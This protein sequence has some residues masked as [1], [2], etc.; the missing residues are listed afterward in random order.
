MLNTIYDSLSNPLGTARLLE[1][2][3][4]LNR[5]DKAGVTPQQMRAIFTDLKGRSDDQIRGF[6]EI[7]QDLVSG[8]ARFEGNAMPKSPNAPRLTPV[9]TP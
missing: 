4:T 1:G 3:S 7:S 8:K 2:F 5:A 6:V 9:P